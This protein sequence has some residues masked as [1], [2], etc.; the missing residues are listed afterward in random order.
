MERS[1][2]VGRFACERTF[3]RCVA[4]TVLLS[5]NDCPHCNNRR[6]N[7]RMRTPIC[8]YAQPPHTYCLPKARLDDICIMVKTDKLHLPH[9]G[10]QWCFVTRYCQH[11]WCPHTKTALT[12]RCEYLGQDQPPYVRMH[13]VL[14]CVCQ[15]PAS[16]ASFPTRS[17]QNRLHPSPCTTCTVRL[18]CELLKVFAFRIDDERTR[19]QERSRIHNIVVVVLQRRS[20]SGDSPRQ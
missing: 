6:A 15:A 5:V 17:D 19:T 12:T 13:C 7:D 18:L 4:A 10:L 20:I 8:P 3:C 2:H 11:F 14:R 16:T 1:T 9:T